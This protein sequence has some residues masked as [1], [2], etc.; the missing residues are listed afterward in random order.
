MQEV[1]ILLCHNLRLDLPTIVLQ[2]S[3]QRALR[4]LRIRI[5]TGCGS[6]R[7]LLPRGA[8]DIWPLPLGPCTRPRHAVQR[9]ATHSKSEKLGWRCAA[10]AGTWLRISIP[11]IPCTEREMQ[12]RNVFKALLARA[13]KTQKHQALRLRKP[14]LPRLPFRSPHPTLNPQPL[15]TGKGC[16][17]WPPRDAT[18]TRNNQPC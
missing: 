13:T 14:W 5:Q 3:S 6:F 10:L 12:R 2:A 7:S 4:D 17:G 8:G 15:L 11:R 1:I 16:K 18:A 9:K